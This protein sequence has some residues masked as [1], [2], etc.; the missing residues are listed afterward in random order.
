MS[1]EASPFGLR[2]LHHNS[3]TVLR[4]EG[5][6]DLAT[7]PQLRSRLGHV[8]ADADGPILLDLADLTFIDSTGLRAILTAHAELDEQGRDLCVIKAS[9]QVRRLFE[10]CGISDLLIDDPQAPASNPMSA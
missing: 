10:L 6:L 1:A 5:E 7:A 3:H 4:V 9:V 2:V 8:I